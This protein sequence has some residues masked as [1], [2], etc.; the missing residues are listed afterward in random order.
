MH[1]PSGWTG[2]ARSGAEDEDD[3]AGESILLSRTAAN[4]FGSNQTATIPSGLDCHWPT[5]TGRFSA[6]VQ[7]KKQRRSTSI[8]SR[9][10]IR[11]IAGARR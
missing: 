4:F 5:V 1:P 11:W 3:E 9:L 7:K 6:R 8:S 10:L 2:C